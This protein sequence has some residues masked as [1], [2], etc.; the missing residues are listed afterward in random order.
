MTSCPDCGGERLV[1][2][3]TNTSSPAFRPTGLRLFCFTM[4]DLK[5]KQGNRFVACQDCGLI[6]SGIDE[7]ALVA[8]L[9]DKGNNRTRKQFR[10][11][12]G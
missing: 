9:S 6:W 2:G 10:L 1:L 5:P 3:T 11:T 4:S 8:L 12:S 7:A